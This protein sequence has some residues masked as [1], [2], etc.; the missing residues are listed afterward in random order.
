MTWQQ[1]FIHGPARLF[2]ALVAGVLWLDD[3]VTRGVVLL[4]YAY[5]IVAG[6]MGALCLLGAA[7]TLLAYL[8]GVPHALGWP[9]PILPDVIP[10]GPRA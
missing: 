6:S 1:F 2:D 4:Y 7:L 10:R 3:V 9:D 5:W 8:L